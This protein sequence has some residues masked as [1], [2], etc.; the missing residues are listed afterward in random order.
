MLR[1]GGMRTDAN[2]KDEKLLL[3]G[4]L[5]YANRVAV[6]NAL[7]V[8]LADSYREDARWLCDDIDE[9]R[10]ELTHERDRVERQHRQIMEREAEIERL[11]AE[12][13]RLRTP[14]GETFLQ[15]FP[16]K[17]SMEAMESDASLGRLVRA[18][19]RGWEL[20][21]TSD[22]TEWRVQKHQVDSTQKFAHAPEE[23][24]LA[25]GVAGTAPD[26]PQLSEMARTVL[27]E[28]AQKMAAKAAATD[29]SQVVEARQTWSVESVQDAAVAAAE[30]GRKR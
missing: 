1:E 3:N 30:R 7:A 4:G 23:A 24:L 26:N 19:P 14:T 9:L 11:T 29:P 10:A 13:N 17:A 5:T 15:A 2:W 16:D 18:M 28:H 8:A 21:H 12:V 6:G 27:W 25:A 22:G 20:Y